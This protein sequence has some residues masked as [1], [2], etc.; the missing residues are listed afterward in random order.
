MK[1][2]HY[3]VWFLYFDKKAYNLF[4]KTE[5]YNKKWSFTTLLLK[6]VVNNW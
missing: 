2:D 4:E 1:P 5:L 6:G 3:M